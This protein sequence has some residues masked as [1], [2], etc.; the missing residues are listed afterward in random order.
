MAGSLS[1]T[2]LFVRNQPGGMFAVED[3]S[4]STGMRFY[5]DSSNANAADAAGA[6]YNPDRPFATIDYAFSSGAVVASRGDIIYVAPG[7]TETYTT[8]GTKLTA[9][10]A[11]VRIV[12][13]GQGAS[14]P[15]LTFSH[16]D[17][18][19][20]ISANGVTI[21]NVLFV[22]GVD[23]VTTY[24]T[25][26][27]TDCQLID[28]EDRDTTDVEAITPF[29][30]TGARFHGINHFHNGYVGGD[31]CVRVFSL[32]AAHGS[33]FDK[34]RLHGKWTTAGIN[35]VGAS[36][37]KVD[38]LS[39]VFY[40]DGTSLSKNV[41]DT[42]GSSTWTA[43]DCFDLV[44]GAGFSGGSGGALAA[45]DVGAVST[46]L[47]TLSGKIGTPSNT[48]GAATL[49]AQLG[50]MANVSLAT[51][52]GAIASSVSAIPLP[53]YGAVN[54]L[55]VLA[56][57]SSATWNTQATHEIFTVTGAVRMRILAECVGTLTDAADTATISLGPEA[58]G[59]AW[60]AATD[61]AGKNG[62][63]L[64]A[65]QLWYDTSPDAL[66]ATYSTAV[67]DYVIPNGLDVGYAIAGAALTGG[68]IRF[69]CWW[70]QL[71][72]NGAVVAGAGGVLA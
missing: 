52:L 24:A 32:N 64:T 59:T 26:S 28:C 44:G 29:T 18:T 46:A 60:I 16:A 38:V 9:N 61:A 37:L 23:L 27:G 50:D 31:A 36:S 49:A 47:T 13:L 72:A 20:V 10:V 39:S 56:D 3:Q 8:T 19:L 12:G 55:S 57:M 45:D 63:T 34:C 2:P 5:V 15:T 65:G 62:Q 41:V 58:T 11:G 51:R 4:L 53:A 66:A 68:S 1:R 22:A 69:H 43:K 67:L 70:E 40:C 25:I 14:R 17:A 42:I 48:G 21:D 54:Y 71:N 7:H 30:V 6:G 35:F 33:V